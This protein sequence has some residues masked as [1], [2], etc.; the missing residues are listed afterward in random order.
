MG[1]QEAL[2]VLGIAEAV[3]EQIPVEAVAAG[4]ARMAT[5]AALPTLEADSRIV[6]LE[7][8]SALQG[9]RGQDL[10]PVPSRLPRLARQPAGRLTV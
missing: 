10:V 2:G 5:G 4:V 6:E 7:F 3:V 8:S 1:Q 9:H